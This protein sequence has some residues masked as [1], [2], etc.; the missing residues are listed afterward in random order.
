M[1]R[2]TK[3]LSWEKKD[4]KLNLFVHGK[5]C[6]KFQQYTDDEIFRKKLSKALSH[7]T[8]FR[9]LVWN[10]INEEKLLKV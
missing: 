8:D 1:Q 5:P 9:I 6:E 7:K 10:E 3:T 2:L 4:R